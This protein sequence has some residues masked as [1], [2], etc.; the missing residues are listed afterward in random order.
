[1]AACKGLICST[2]S[3]HDFDPGYTL[4]NIWYYLVSGDTPTGRTPT[5]I[6][7]DPLEGIEGTPLLI[8]CAAFWDDGTFQPPAAITLRADDVLFQDSRLTFS[9]NSTHKLY[10]L[11]NLTQSDEGVAFTCTIGEASSPSVTVTVL[12]KVSWQRNTLER[13][14]NTIICFILFSCH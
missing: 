1:M 11:D 7:T 9:T 10:T 6:I 8:Q 12:G 13:Q 3:N 5:V 2:L 4:R 14:L